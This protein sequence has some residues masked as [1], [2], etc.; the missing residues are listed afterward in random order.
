MTPERRP[1]G[2]RSLSPNP[3]SPQGLIEF[4]SESRISV[5]YFARQAKE[6][7]NNDLA[8][9]LTVQG[10]TLRTEIARLR[11]TWTTDWDHKTKIL[12]TQGRAARS[13]LAR[14][15]EDAEKS[16]K[17]TRVFTRAID[18]VSTLLALTKKI[19]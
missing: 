3:P 18:A 4:L 17:K 11:R 6:A 2:I 7:K 5:L 13:E 9:E 19:L 10:Q 14:L 15:M 1:K 12:L 16:A 8:K